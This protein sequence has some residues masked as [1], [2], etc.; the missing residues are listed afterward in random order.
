MFRSWV[1]ERCVCTNYLSNNP[2]PMAIRFLEENPQYMH[3]RFLAANPSAISL[4]RPLIENKVDEFWYYDVTPN[5]YWAA[6]S[7]NAAAIDVLLDHPEKINW[8]KFCENTAPEAIAMIEDDFERHDWKTMSHF[9]PDFCADASYRNRFYLC[10]LC[11]NPAAGHILCRPQLMSIFGIGDWNALC[12][13]PAE[14]VVE[15]LLNEYARNPDS[16]RLNWAFVAANPHPDMVDL[17]AENLWRVEKLYSAEYRSHAWMC[18]SG[19]PQPRALALLDKHP[20]KIDYR[21]LSRNPAAEELIR[22]ALVRD[23]SSFENINKICFRS[24][25]G[26]PVIFESPLVVTG[27]KN[28]MATDELD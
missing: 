24:L 20:D 27:Y 16:N 5:P 2:D 23:I 7:T 1:P 11:A 13:N 22:A 10:D 4:V 28:P 25:A 15:F 19:N 17:F 21:G 18:L 12:M 8:F 3:L 9:P 26:N 14:E 6:L